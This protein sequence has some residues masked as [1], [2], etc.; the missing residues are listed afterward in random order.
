[1]AETRR[2]PFFLGEIAEGAG[3]GVELEVLVELEVGLMEFGPLALIGVVD[4]IRLGE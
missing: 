4:D 3:L 1:M 2:L